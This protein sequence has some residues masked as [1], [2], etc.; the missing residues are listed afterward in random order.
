M[1]RSLFFTDVDLEYGDEL[2]TLSTCYYPLTKDAADTRFVV[3]ARRVRE[4][5]SAEVD[6]S[7]AVENSNPLYFDT[8]YKMNGGSWNG[9]NWDAD[10]DS[11]D[12]SKTHLKIKGFEEYY[13]S[14]ETTASTEG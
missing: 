9:R 5:E 1:D 4:G 6:T 2:L 14:H 3:F 10:P 13:K 12:T 8:Y 11:T 7:K